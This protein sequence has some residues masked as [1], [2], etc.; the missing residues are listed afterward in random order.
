MEQ[1]VWGNSK[2]GAK[3]QIHVH[4]QST[5]F[6]IKLICLKS[7]MII[8]SYRDHLHSTDQLKTVTILILVDLIVTPGEVG[9]GKADRFT[10]Q[11][12]E[13]SAAAT[14]ASH[15]AS[16]S[17]AILWQILSNFF[18]NVKKF[19]H[20]WTKVWEKFDSADWVP[21]NEVG[22]ILS[23]CWEKLAKR[24]PLILRS[25]YQTCPTLTPNP[26]ILL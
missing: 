24:K 14:S 5:Q 19:Q 10:K 22:F 9:K 26:G 6:L 18:S 25:L 3:T 23:W 7:N 17:K 12:P 21:R 4:V 16:N 1:G 20:P 8:L 2:T 11:H 15:T 13:I